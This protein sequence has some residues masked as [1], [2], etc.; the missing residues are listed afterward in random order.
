[1]VDPPCDLLIPKLNNVKRP[2]LKLGDL[3]AG[4]CFDIVDLRNEPK[5]WKVPFLEPKTAGKEQGRHLNPENI[6]VRKAGVTV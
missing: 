6:Q 4:G 2:S 5:L 3:S 1:M